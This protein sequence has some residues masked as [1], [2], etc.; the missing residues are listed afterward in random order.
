M[1][2]GSVMGSHYAGKKIHVKRKNILT[3]VFYVIGFTH[4][5]RWWRGRKREAP[6]SQ[7]VK[8][9]A[10]AKA[11]AA[12]WREIFAGCDYVVR[13]IRPYFD[14]DDYMVVMGV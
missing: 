2:S 5:R 3:V 7:R 13:I 10:E 11:L 9:H 4:A 8:T 6:M 1:C 14:G 12:E